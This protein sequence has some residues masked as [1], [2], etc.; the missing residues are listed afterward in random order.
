ML[1][2]GPNRELKSVT[3]QKTIVSLEK[4]TIKCNSWKNLGTS[5]ILCKLTV[6]KSRCSIIAAL[7]QTYI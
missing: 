6:N 2:K 7:L 1:D 4:K 5:F 3:F